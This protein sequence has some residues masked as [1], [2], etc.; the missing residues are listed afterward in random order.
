MRMKI[1]EVKKFQKIR[2]AFELSEWCYSD[3]GHPVVV[4]IYLDSSNS[5]VYQVDDKTK[6]YRVAEDG[7]KYGEWKNEG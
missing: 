7:G 1:E 6:R 5:K 4:S 2:D 3:N